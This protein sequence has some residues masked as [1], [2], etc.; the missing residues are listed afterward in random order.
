MLLP[1]DWE[2]AGPTPRTS[3]SPR[4][5]TRWLASSAS[6]TTTHVVA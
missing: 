5:G 2:Q 3:A 6:W 1:P 4:S